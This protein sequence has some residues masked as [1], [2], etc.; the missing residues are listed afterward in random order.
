MVTCYDY[1][2]LVGSQGQMGHKK[3]VRVL[4]VANEWKLPTII[5]AEGAG[6]RS[7]DTDT[8]SA[9]GLDLSILTC[10]AA[11]AALR[12]YHPSLERQRCLG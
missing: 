10:F 3:F 11:A 8:N 9:A 12:R 4:Y 1:N 2:A 5:F 6:G 7:G